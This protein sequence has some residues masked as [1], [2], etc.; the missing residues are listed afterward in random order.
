MAFTYFF[1]DMQTLEQIADRVLPTLKGHRYINIWDAGCA[2][3]PEPYSV[4]IMLRE[5]MT[6]F[7]FRNVR[8]YATDIDGSSRF[9]ETIA[10]GVYPEDEIKRIPAAVR[11][12][13]FH[14]T[15]TAG[16]YRIADELR[17]R[18]SF[19][20]HDLLSLEPV[21]TGF[22]LIVCKNVLLHFKEEQRVAVVRMFHGA[23][24][25]GGYLAVEHTQPLPGGAAHLF[26]RVSGRG[27]VFRKV[28]R[29][30]SEADV[31]E[32]AGMPIQM[33]S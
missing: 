32:M 24:R 10:E 7:L 5:R 27:Q 30:V 23:L 3:G 16:C 6:R 21:R 19:A 29:C 11:Q 31:T 26:E 25:D 12:K 17:A 2:H 18:V 1:R 28:T 15:E 33:V 8:I 20:R 13:Y 22:S 14:E 9:G 4:A